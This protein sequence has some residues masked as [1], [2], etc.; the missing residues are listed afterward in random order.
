[1]S[2]AASTLPDLIIPTLPPESTI[3]DQGSV[4]PPSLS[5][6]NP[7][8]TLSRIP[9]G[10][11]LVGNSVQVSPGRVDQVAVLVGGGIEIAIEAFTP[12]DAAEMPAGQAVTVREV[13]GVMSVGDVESTLAWI[14][15][16]DVQ[17]SIRAPAEV[18]V[19]TLLEVADALEVS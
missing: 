10:F 18:E 12:S 16:G 8:F 2:A 3:P 19:D 11:D 14:E 15:P 5:P 13:D 6:S 9:A 17:F 1:V 7:L 4:L